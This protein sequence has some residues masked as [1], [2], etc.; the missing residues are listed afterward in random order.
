MVMVL[1]EE[2]LSHA[3]SQFMSKADSDQKTLVGQVII[4]GS[5]LCSQT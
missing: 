5:L 3:S 1:A 2:R 4:F